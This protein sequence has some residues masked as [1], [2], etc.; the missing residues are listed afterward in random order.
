M[1]FSRKNMIFLPL[2]W[3][4]SDYCLS[5]NIFEGNLYNFLG[6]LGPVTSRVDLREAVRG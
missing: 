1:I 3:P 5:Q 6:Y 2:P 4:S